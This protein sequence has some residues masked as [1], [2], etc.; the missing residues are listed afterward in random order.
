MCEGDGSLGLLLLLHPLHGLLVGEGDGSLMHKKLGRI[1]VRLGLTRETDLADDVRMPGLAVPGNVPAWEGGSMVSLFQ[2][3]CQL[4]RAVRITT[5]L[6][7]SEAASGK[8]RFNKCCSEL[9][10]VGNHRNLERE[11]GKDTT[12]TADSSMGLEQKRGSVL[13]LL[14][15]FAK[16][17]HFI[18]PTGAESF[19][20]LWRHDAR[21]YSPGF[22]AV[23]VLRLNFEKRKIPL[24]SQRVLPCPSEQF[25]LLPDDSRSQRI[26]SGRSGSVALLCPPL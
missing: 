6:D 8:D 1:D 18:F 21:R 4:G 10:I 16:I 25:W 12:Y 23:L 14:L 20:F 11:E 7:R 24:G 5:F 15:I 26:F 17:M 2:G 13:V 3:T 9:H 22:T 19:R